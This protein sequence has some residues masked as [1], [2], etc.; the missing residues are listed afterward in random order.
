MRRRTFAQVAAE[1]VAKAIR[2][3]RA[4]VLAYADEY[5]GQIDA[6]LAKRRITAAEAA[7]LKRRV[8][9]FAEGVAAGLHAHG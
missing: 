7:T 6:L 5:G 2:D 9:G 3:E 1:A 8:R 4:A